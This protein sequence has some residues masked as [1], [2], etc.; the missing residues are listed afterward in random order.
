MGSLPGSPSK[1]TVAQT[2]SSESAFA[3]FGSTVPEVTASTSTPKQSDYPSSPASTTTTTSS[4]ALPASTASSST[5]GFM[6]VGHPKISTSTS[7]ASHL[8]PGKIA[9][10]V[11]SQMQQDPREASGMFHR[12]THLAVEAYAK[13][14]ALQSHKEDMEKVISCNVFL[15]NVVGWFSYLT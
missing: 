3:S 13:L 9:C 5:S 7:S 12:A 6:V 2:K 10:D 14:D 4:L 11:M 8:G 1:D 15:Y